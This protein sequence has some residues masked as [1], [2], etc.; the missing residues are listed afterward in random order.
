MYLRAFFVGNTSLFT[1]VPE[2]PLLAF[3]V[4]LALGLFCRN[5]CVF[6]CCLVIINNFEEINY[7]YLFVVLFSLIQASLLLEGYMFLKKLSLYKGN[8]YL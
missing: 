7:I 2:L 3:K 4:L 5:L 1:S 8:I 6:D